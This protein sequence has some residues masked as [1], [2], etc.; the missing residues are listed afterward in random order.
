[1]QV[2]LEMNWI[3]INKTIS[4]TTKNPKL[5]IDHEA[6]YS[7]VLN[8]LFEKNSYIHLNLHMLS[9][10]MKL[11]MLLCFQNLGRTF[12]A[13]SPGSMM[14]KLSPPCSINILINTRGDNLTTEWNYLYYT[15]YLPYLNY[16]LPLLII[17]YSYSTTMV[18][19][20]WK[21]SQLALDPH[22]KK[23]IFLFPA[24]VLLWCMGLK[25]FYLTGPSPKK[26]NVSDYSTT[27]VN[28]KWVLL[29]G[30]M[31]FNDKYVDSI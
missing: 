6:W 8:N 21:K 19:G 15:R 10:L 27:V 31:M 18:H 5:W 12:L 24:T 11:C 4:F 25:K 7:S 20:T 30:I 23:Y 16:L 9:C 2:Q 17:F 26:E 1:M 14:K 3:L 13:N 29:F 22:R 28:R